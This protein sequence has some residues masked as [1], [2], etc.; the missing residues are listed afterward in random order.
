MLQGAVQLGQAYV[1]LCEIGDVSHLDWSEEYRCKSS[2]GKRIIYEIQSKC[3]EFEQLY[4]T[5]RE[6]IN[7]MRMKCHELNFFTIQQLLFLRKE[8]ASLKRGLTLESL[9]LQVYSLLE[10]ALP[11]LHRKILQEAL[12]EAG[13]WSPDSD[14]DFYSGEDARNTTSQSSQDDTA[15]DNE[16]ISEKYE[17]LFDNVEKFNPSEPERLAVAA[18]YNNTE[19]NIAEL[20]LWCVQNKD[21]SDLIDEFYEK[22]S[23][24]PKFRDI[25]GENSDSDEE[26]SQSSQHSDEQMR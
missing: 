14:L 20:V 2:M 8:L 12:R 4:H 26:S 6:H 9:N 3:K 13:I 5:C 24:D 19:G 17:S 18:L 21:K 22:A 25:I 11:G 1:N 16:M 23:E 7:E 15:R 10:K